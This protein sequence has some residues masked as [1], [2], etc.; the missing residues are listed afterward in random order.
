VEK[1]KKSDK[2]SDAPWVRADLRVRFVDKKYK[3]GRYYNAKMSVFDVVSKENCSL[4]DEKGSIIDGISQQWLETV[5]P[6]SDGQPVM[7]LR[8]EFRG[9]VGTIVDRDRKRQRASVQISRTQDIV[10]LSFDDVCE[11]CGDATIYLD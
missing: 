11:F 4:R 6:R 7:V 1:K 10:T 9:D 3:N 5:I 2:S 8:G